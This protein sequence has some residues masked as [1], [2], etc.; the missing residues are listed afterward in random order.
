[1]IPNTCGELSTNYPSNLVI[2]RSEKGEEED[3]D[4]NGSGGHEVRE[5]N[6]PS[7]NGLDLLLESES[8][9]GSSFT[10]NGSTNGLTHH[11]TDSI[12]ISKSTNN[13]ENGTLDPSK[14]KEL[15]SRARFARCR[16]RFPVPVI[17][18]NKKHICRLVLLLFFGRCLLLFFLKM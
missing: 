11:N 10:L 8:F 3:E 13:N 18:Y 5:F 15:C 9:M 1:M 12:S 4:V 16:A 2:L 17:L 7:N 14:L 6:P